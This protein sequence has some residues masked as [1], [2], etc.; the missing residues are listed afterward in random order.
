MLGLFAFGAR[1][2]FVCVRASSAQF[3][4]KFNVANATRLAPFSAPSAPRAAPFH[5][6][7]AVT[8]AFT[9]LCSPFLKRLT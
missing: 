6:A 7:I 3:G 4:A 5:D 2:V 9:G 1:R 8:K